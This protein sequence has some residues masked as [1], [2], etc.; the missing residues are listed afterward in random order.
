MRFGTF[1]MFAVA[2]KAAL[3]LPQSQVHRDTGPRDIS[4]YLLTFRLI[5][6]LEVRLPCHGNKVSAKEWRIDPPADYA[7]RQ[8]HSFCYNR[9]C[10]ERMC[11]QRGCLVYHWNMCNIHRSCVRSVFTSVFVLAKTDILAGSGFTLTSSKGK[12]AVVS[13]VFTCASTVSTATVFTVCY[14]P[15]SYLLPSRFDL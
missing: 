3:L 12:C 5:R 13:N 8:R 14:A 1:S 10:A 4:H 11:Y 7:I 15:I 9:W 6:R 2:C